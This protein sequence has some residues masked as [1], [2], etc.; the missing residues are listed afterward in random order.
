MLRDLPADEI[1]R[2]AGTIGAVASMIFRRSHTL[3]DTCLAILSNGAQICWDNCKICC[4]MTIGNNS[5][6]TAAGG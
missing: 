2:G 6:M 4:Q 1:W 5:H 3:V